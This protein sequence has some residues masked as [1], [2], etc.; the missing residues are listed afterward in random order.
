MVALLVEMD[1]NCLYATDAG[2]LMVRR[3]Q[4]RRGKPRMSSCSF[5]NTAR[6]MIAIAVYKAG[7]RETVICAGT[8]SCWS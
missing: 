7:C 4:F 2:G 3:M 5:N 6:K 1:A 8:G